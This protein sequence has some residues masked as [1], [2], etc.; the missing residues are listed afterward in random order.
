[1]EENP[2]DARIGSSSLHRQLEETRE[3]EKREEARKEAERKEAE[4]AAEKARQE[5][6]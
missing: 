5:E 6:Q 4:V 3:A 1:M 2:I